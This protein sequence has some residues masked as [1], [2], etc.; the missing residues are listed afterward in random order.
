MTRKFRL[1]LVS[2][3]G[4]DQDILFPETSCFGLLGDVPPATEGNRGRPYD[5]DSNCFLSSRVVA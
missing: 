3:S 2:R 4:G 5:K 1:S